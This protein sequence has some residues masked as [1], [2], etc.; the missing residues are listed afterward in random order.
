MDYLRDHWHGRHALPQAFWINFLGPFLLFAMAEPSIRPEAGA[1]SVS[2]GLIAS[3]YILLTHAL[4]LP[5][6][7]VGLWRSCRRH[8]VERGDLFIVTFAQSAI[9]VALVTA[10]G[11]TTTTVLRIFEGGQGAP[12]SAPSAAIYDLWLAP[13]AAAV[14]IDGSFD[15]GLTRDLE[16]LLAQHPR[17]EA[18]VLNSNGGRVFEARGVARQIIDHKLDTYVFDVCR[19]ACTIAFIAGHTRH[20]GEEAKL[21]FH[22]Y[23]LDGHAV[24][25]DPL[26]EQA[27]DQ[28]FFVNQGVQSDFSRRAFA[29][30]HDDMWDPPIEQLLR[31]HVVHQVIDG[32]VTASFDFHRLQGKRPESGE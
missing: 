15:H 17:I 16:A 30:P 23:R 8:L 11:A 20:I 4:I 9:L 24:L 29:T 2:N 25:T 31:A 27:K 19:S 5:W 13:D 10:A 12:V 22:S 32:G 26:A 1:V 7:V 28:S 3:V 21:G 18:V 14:S 6:Q